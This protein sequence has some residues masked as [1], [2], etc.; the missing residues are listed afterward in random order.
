MPSR[1]NRILALLTAAAVL[2]M[3]IDCPCSGGI[4]LTKVAV[5]AGG[6]A[7]A[8][9][10]P[11]CARHDCHATDHHCSY[12]RDCAQK[13]RPKPCDG[14]CEHC[15]QT[16][17]NDSV[18]M[19]SHCLSSHGYALPVTLSIDSMAD[20]DRIDLS[21]RSS[22]PIPADLPPPLNSPTLLSQHCALTN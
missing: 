1:L 3:S 12:V 22:A 14:A 2:L 19:P 11:C 17:I 6:D 4:G 9:Q 5:G 15:G 10:M 21:W 8:G 16:V 13:H 20:R 7:Q 18:S